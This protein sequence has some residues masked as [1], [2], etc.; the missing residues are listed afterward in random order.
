[1]ARFVVVDDFPF[2]FHRLYHRVTLFLIGS[3]PPLSPQQ[4]CNLVDCSTLAVVSCKCFLYVRFPCLLFPTCIV[5]LISAVLACNDS[6]RV[7]GT[8]QVSSN[9]AHL[10]P[11]AQRLPSPS[12]ICQGTLFSR[13]WRSPL[14]SYFEGFHPS[15]SLRRA[16]ER[17]SA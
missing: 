12:R 2:H 16:Q 10:R 9:E 8:Y 13:P 6:D 1:V 11:L 5:L 4:L 7:S 3:H 17:V 15:F 14:N